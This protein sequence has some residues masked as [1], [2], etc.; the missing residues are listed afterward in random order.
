MVFNEQQKK[1]WRCSAVAE[2][3]AIYTQL[4]IQMPQKYNVSPGGQI[5]YDHEVGLVH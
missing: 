2:S 4:L 1:G 5:Q 3:K